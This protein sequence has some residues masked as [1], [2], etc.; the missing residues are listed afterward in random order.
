MLIFG[1]GLALVAVNLR[2][3]DRDRALHE[4]QRLA[5]ALEHAALAAQWRARSIAWSAGGGGAY[6]FLSFEPQG[7]SDAWKP[8]EDDTLLA[9]RVLPPSMVLG[10]I[11]VAGQNSAEPRLVFHA[12]GINDGFS[13]QLQFAD[14]RMII[15]GD[16]LGRVQVRPR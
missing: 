8:V 15:E 1:L 14:A 16:A 11:T 7:G 10:E 6:R 4:A 2:E 5:Q 9:P 3:S 13:L 12:N